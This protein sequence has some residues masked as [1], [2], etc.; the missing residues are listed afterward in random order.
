M[1]MFMWILSLLYLLF[2][3]PLM[4]SLMVFLISIVISFLKY[5]ESVGTNLFV[6]LF[7]MVY[8]GGL[9]L[10]LMYMSSLVPNYNMSIKFSLILFLVFFVIFSV[11]T[12]KYFSFLGGF[13][14]SFTSFSV[15]SYVMNFKELL[16]MVVFLLMFI[17]CFLSSILNVFKYPIRS[18]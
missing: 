17:F 11:Y 13:D 6:Y 10:M 4:M 18:L 12:E 1:M 7:I 9:L 5:F 8:S 2:S 14:F 3:H 16:Y 15:I